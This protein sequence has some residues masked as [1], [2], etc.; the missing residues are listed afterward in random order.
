MCYPDSWE[1]RDKWQIVFYRYPI[2]SG[3][4][5]R[6]RNAFIQGVKNI[7]VAGDSSAW[8]NYPIAFTKFAH[9]VG[10]DLTAQKMTW[11]WSISSGSLS[12]CSL[13]S[14]HDARTMGVIAIGV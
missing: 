14:T 6:S 11:S 8:V 13:V 7:Y 5:R 1:S 4:K 12:G 9:P 3:F 2:K 10:A